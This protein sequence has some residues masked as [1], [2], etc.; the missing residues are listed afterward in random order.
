MFAGRWKWAVVTAVVLIGTASRAEVPVVVFDVPLTTECRDVTPQG[1]REAYQREIIEAVFKVS[2]QLMVGEEAD[3]KKLHYEISTEQQMPVVSYLPNA[4]VATDVVNGTIAIQ[5]SSHHGEISFRYLILPTTGDGNLTGNLESSH[6]QF[7]LLAPKQLLIAAGT[8][9]RGCGVYFQLRQSSQDTL[10]KQREFACLFDVPAAWRAD[11]V[12]V[13]CSAK[14]IKRGLGGL[15]DSDV[16]CGSGLLSVGLYKREDGEARAYADM[17]ARKQQVYLSQLAEQA[18]KPR[19]SGLLTSLTALDRLLSG[20]KT[21]AQLSKATAV[22]AAVQSQ[23]EEGRSSAVLQEVRSG[24]GL[25]AEDD[26]GHLLGVPQD[27]RAAFE[28]MKAAKDE[29]RRMNGKDT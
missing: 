13:R 20:T 7:G 18:R 8:I 10:Q 5:N 11:A 4:E 12:T 21:R 19:P 22:G 24:G 23:I 16:D 6:A 26:E 27:A 9:E 28:Q 1:F 3:L 17:L 29:L 15:L 2:P 14:G 25:K